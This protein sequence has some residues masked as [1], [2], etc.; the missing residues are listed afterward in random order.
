MATR[1]PA[2]TLQAASAAGAAK[3]ATQ[4]GPTPRFA[5]L[6]ILAGA[7]IALGGILSVVLGYGMPGLTAD[8]PAIQK[9]LS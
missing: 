9:L 2:E 4:H 1:T 6:T 3:L 8:N 5:L 7:Y